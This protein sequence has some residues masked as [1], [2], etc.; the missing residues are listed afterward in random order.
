MCACVCVCWGPG[1]VLWIRKWELSWKASVSLCQEKTFHMVANFSNYLH[2]KWLPDDN[3]RKWTLSWQYYH[4]QIYSFTPITEWDVVF[5]YVWHEFPPGMTPSGVPVSSWTHKR[6]TFPFNIYQ[7]V[8]QRPAEQANDCLFAEN[9]RL[10]KHSARWQV[11]YPSKHAKIHLLRVSRPSEGQSHVFNT[12]LPG[13]ERGLGL[14][15]LSC[16]PRSLPSSCLGS[17]AKPCVSMRGS[18]N[19]RRLVP[20]EPRPLV[21]SSNLISS[22]AG[23][24][25]RQ[26]GLI[27]KNIIVYPL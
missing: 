12:C 23:G 6:F 15:I 10:Q 5:F 17:D 19:P 18:A 16:R 11:L 2:V 25:Q 22:P 1:Q 13:L 8:Q 21:H 14:G 27:W 20:V 24:G 26:R 3:G 9:N 4:F 7:S